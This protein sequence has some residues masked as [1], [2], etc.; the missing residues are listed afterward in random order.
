MEM[1]ILFNHVKHNE[2]GEAIAS[3]TSCSSSRLIVVV[4]VEVVDTV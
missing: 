1:A 2:S 4:V 3:L